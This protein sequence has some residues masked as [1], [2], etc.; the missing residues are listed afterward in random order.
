M[1]TRLFG[2]DDPP[3]LAARASAR[4][5]VPALWIPPSKR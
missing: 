5:L 2:A 3:S 4:L 1:T